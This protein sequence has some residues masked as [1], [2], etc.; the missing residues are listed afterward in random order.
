[1]KQARIVAACGMAAALS[2]V[3]ML[4]GGILGLGMY[5]APMIAGACLLPIGRSYGRKYHGMLWLA[6]S[7]LCF[8][9][10]PNVEENLMY[11]A[12]FGP[13]PL[14]Y[15]LFQ[16]LK[17]PWRWLCKLLYFNLV[18]VAVEALVIFLLVPE[19]LTPWMTVTLLALGNLTFILY[20]RLLPRLAAL[21]HRRLSRLKSMR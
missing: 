13:Y 5:A 3:I 6:V 1:M 8:L 4:L 10:V 9:L 7:L 18:T 12:L 16:R 11:L 19:V 2:V 14:L 17:Q 21:L 20:D 15:P